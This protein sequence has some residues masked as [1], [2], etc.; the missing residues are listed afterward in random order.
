VVR[1]LVE[2]GADKDK[3]NDFGIT[4]LQIARLTGHFEIVAYLSAAGCV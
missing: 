1:Y 2:Q 4:P 3:P